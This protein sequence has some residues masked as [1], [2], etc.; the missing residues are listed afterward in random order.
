MKVIYILCTI[1]ID[2]VPDLCTHSF[3]DN[4]SPSAFLRRPDKKVPG[5]RLEDGVD[6][7]L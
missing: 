3:P 7:H 5:P 4:H 6:H 1:L 2:F